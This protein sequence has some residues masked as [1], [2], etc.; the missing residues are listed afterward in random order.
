MEASAKRKTSLTLNADAL[1]AA[2]TFGVNVSA[3]ADAALQRAVSEARRC[4]WME[5]NAQEAFA[6]QAQWHERN[7][8]P[9]ADILAGP[10]GTTWKS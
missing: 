4:Q 1:D 5:E 10:A 8:H 9:L 3:V 7:R 2:R 6:A